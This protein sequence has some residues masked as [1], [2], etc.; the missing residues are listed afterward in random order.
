MNRI[1]LASPPALRNT[2]QNSTQRPSA[3]ATRS[4]Q[5]ARNNRISQSRAADECNWWGDRL[6]MTQA[7]MV[8]AT[9]ENCLVH[10]RKIQAGELPTMY[11]DWLGFKVTTSPLSM[12]A[13]SA[14][15]FI[16]LLPE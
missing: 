6:C 14:K 1:Q 5:N 7:T 15:K 13:V 9:R 10:W 8:N 16:L 4:V 11:G 3:E 12:V 2:S